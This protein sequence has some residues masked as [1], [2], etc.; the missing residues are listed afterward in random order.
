[1]FVESI[2]TKQQIII[3]NNIKISDNGEIL[4]AIIATT[5]FRSEIEE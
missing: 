5:C 3:N 2:A 1:M 4:R